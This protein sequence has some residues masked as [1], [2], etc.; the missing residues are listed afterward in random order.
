[1]ANRGN[2]GD[3][4]AASVDNQGGDGDEDEDDFNQQRMIDDYERMQ[5][6]QTQTIAQFTPSPSR[7]PAPRGRGR[8]RRH[9][10][11]S[12]PAPQQQIVVHTGGGGANGQF[13]SLAERYRQ[14]R[15]RDME[16]R[17]PDWEDTSEEEV[18]EVVEEQESEEESEI[19]ND[20]SS[21][22]EEDNQP[23]DARERRK[24]KS[25]NSSE[26]SSSSSSQSEEET[27]S[28]PPSPRRRV[29][30]R[31]E[32]RRPD[33]P[34]QRRR[35]RP[36]LLYD[37]MGRPQC[38]LCGWGNR[39]HE[40]VDPEKMLNLRAILSKNYG[41]RANHEIARAMHL[42]FKHEIYPYGDRR[43]QM[44]TTACALDH[45]ENLHTLNSRIFLGE[46]IKDEKMMYFSFKNAVWKYDGTWDEKAALQYRASKKELRQLYAMN[47]ERMNFKEGETVEDQKYAAECIN[48]MTRFD[49]SGGGGGNKRTTA[50]PRGRGKSNG[51]P[52][53]TPF[54]L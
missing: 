52:A 14:D 4:W 18:V 1:M 19:G 48:I 47:Y 29:T 30:A 53:T 31:P 45:I 11:P 23:A 16:E 51:R 46:M 28:P 24:K 43:M 33:P 12:P 10:S 25:G 2:L 32:E 5:R 36:P 40:G 13:I 26:D 41:F 54:R 7:Q 39:Y 3:V 34:D 17:R 9:A 6:A 35:G 49:A 50:T 22:G 44:L 15:N 42:Y 8:G 20:S 21:G 37:A 38:F 27:A